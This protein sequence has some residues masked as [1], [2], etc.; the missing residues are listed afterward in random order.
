M[1]ADFPAAARFVPGTDALVR[2]PAVP[3]SMSAATHLDVGVD[4][5]LAPAARDRLLRAVLRHAVFREAIAISGD[6]L[7]AGLDAIGAGDPVDTAKADRVADAVAQYLL[8]ACARPTPFGLFAGVAAARFDAVCKVRLGPAGRKA[9]RVDV[10]WLTAHLT[11]LER[12]LRVLRCLRVTAN[13][14][15][16]PRGD[17][18]VLPYVPADADAAAGPAAELSVKRTGPVA[19]AM[20][21]AARPV[22]FAELADRVGAAFPGASASTVEAMLAG[23]VERDL[24]VTDLHPPAVGSGDPLDHAISRLTALDGPEVATLREIRALLADYTATPVGAGRPAWRRAVAAL[25]AV[26]PSARPPVQVDLR[27]DAEVVLPSAI[28]TE[29]A[30]AAA[31]LCRMAPADPVPAHLREYHRAF[32]ERYGTHQLVP[33]VELVDPERGLGAPAGY[34]VP[35]ADRVLAGGEEHPDD[36]DAALAALA[37]LALLDGTGELVLDDA[38]VDRLAP[39]RALP[40]SAELCVQVLATSAAALDRGEFRL[41]VSPAVGAPTAGEMAGRFAYLLDRPLVPW[42]AD[43]PSGPLPVQLTF[44]PLH[45]R[46]GNLLQVPAVTAHSL[47]IGTFAERADPLVLGS[48]DI[49]VGSD[50]DRL[51]L[52]APRL[53]REV[54]AVSPHRVNLVETA[55]NVVRLVREIS[56]TSHRGLEGWWWGTLAGRLPHQPRVRH[57]RTVLAPATWRVPNTLR[58]RAL[59]WREWDRELDAWRARWRVPERIST[60]L[61]DA[62]LDLDLGHGLHRRLLRRELARR[63]D[64]V[65]GEVIGSDA[66]TRWLDGHA[67][68]VVVPVHGPTA[69]RPAVRVARFVRPP[70]PHLPGGE[71]LHAKLY[72]SPGRHHELLA[73]HVAPLVDELRAERWFFIRYADPDP[74]LR[75][76][77]HGDEPWLTGVALPRLHSWADGLCRA[78]LAARLVLDAYEPESARYGGPDLLPAAE[79]VFAAD[80]AAVLEQLRLPDPPAAPEIVAAAGY[81]DILDAFGDTDRYAWFLDQFPRNQHHRD[82]RALRT[83]AVALLVAADG[84]AAPAPRLLAPA[85]RPGRTRAAAA[86]GEAARASKADR[87][88]IL[89][90]LLH[91]HHNRLVGIDRL[92]EARSLAVARA[93]VEARCHRARRAR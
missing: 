59:S 56:T 93:V 23:L 3:G 9:A 58:E 36:R 13:D 69:R 25:R 29:A 35:T 45:G 42:Q 40:A 11:R 10:G 68:E 43:E 46:I 70:A 55:A 18:L 38:M 26:A 19:L 50:G 53:G 41:V 33:L 89:P 65:V 30:A 80:S 22:G 81:L 51:H 92:S 8:R 24:L 60:T 72:A 90:A 75:L 14:L 61:S 52:A 82:L 84:E 48:A 63:G 86:Y 78:G 21:L 66:D 27:I 87:D 5:R 47:A 73:E 16:F 85:T 6:A 83:T 12:D 1:P 2:I 91:M 15:C 44:R 64:T 54:V 28:A 71:W 31:V 39:D 77:L 49:A 32:V 74:H 62:R 57:G 79:A 34:R 37:Q 4:G 67:C 88:V 76:R 7:A 17:R 20:E